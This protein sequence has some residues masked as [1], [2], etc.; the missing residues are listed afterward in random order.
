[1]NA[2]L[3]VTIVCFGLASSL[4]VAGLAFLVLTALRAVMGPLLRTW[5]NYQLD[6]HVRATVLSMQAQ[7]DA[8]GQ[9]VG[10]PA[11]GRLAVGAGMRTAFVLTAALL[12]PV[13]WLYTRSTDAGGR[14]P[15]AAA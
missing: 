5:T 2:G 8:L 6:A 15:R 12:G 13:Q 7:C 4:L 11:I 10:G 3:I 14:D 9:L 1:V